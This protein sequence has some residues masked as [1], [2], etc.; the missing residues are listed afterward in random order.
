MSS[1]GD[2]NGDGF[3]DVIIGDPVDSAN[4]FQAGA[5][6]VL[7]GKASGFA[8]TLDLSTLDGHNGFVLEGREANDESSSSV[9]SAGDVNG[10]GF[11]DLIVGAGSNGGSEGFSYVVF[12]KASGFDAHIDL[13]NLDSKSGFQLDVENNGDFSGASVSGAGDVNGDGFDDLLIGAQRTGSSY[14]IFGGLDVVSGGLPG[15]FGTSMDDH[16]QGTSAAEHLDAGDGDDILL[17]V[18]RT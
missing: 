8:A 4:D 3:D 16:L 13:S 14:V 2:V 12:G 9:S 15:I 1:A 11:D 5:S 10:D 17:G 18:C 6:F 7:F